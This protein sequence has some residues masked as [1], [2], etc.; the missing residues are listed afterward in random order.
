MASNAVIKCSIV[1]R[2]TFKFLNIRLGDKQIRV[3]TTPWITVNSLTRNEKC[4][5]A[6]LEN[7]KSAEL[8]SSHLLEG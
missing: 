2:I 3:I 4:F 7:E 6:T 1:Q 8:C 5:V